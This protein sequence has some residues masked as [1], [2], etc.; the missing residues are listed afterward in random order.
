MENRFDA[1]AKAL[2]AGDGVEAPGVSRREALR[3]VGAGLAGALLA[4]LGMGSAWG[5]PGHGGGGGA[6][7]SDPCKQY[8]SRYSTKAEQNH[9]AQVCRACPSTTM[10]CGTD[11]FN[12]VCCTTTCC[13]GICTDLRTDPNNCAAC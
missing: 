12:L 6:V 5:Q 7:G 11:G 1:A 9:C 3:K 10:L 13:S 2:A 8:C 4:L